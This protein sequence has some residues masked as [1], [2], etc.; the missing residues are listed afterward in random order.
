[1][2]MREVITCIDLGPADPSRKPNGTWI[3]LVT[4]YDVSDER[5]FRAVVDKNRHRL[6]STSPYFRPMVN[7]VDERPLLSGAVMERA[8]PPILVEESQPILPLLESVKGE[9]YIVVEVVVVVV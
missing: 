4:K 8:S 1:M 6:P 2:P 9:H 7:P 3:F 5:T